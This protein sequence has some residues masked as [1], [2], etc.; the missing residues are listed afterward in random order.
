M[1]SQLQ[2]DQ[3]KTSQ[4]EHQYLN[5]YGI[6][7]DPFAADILLVTPE[8]E[9]LLRLLSH[10]V[11]YG[12]KLIV[13]TGEK[14][15][16]KTT[17]LEEFLRRQSGNERLCRISALKLD[18]PNQV[19]RE[20]SKAFELAADETPDKALILV[21]LSGFFTDLATDAE[22][23]MI[24]IDDAHLL[25][26]SVLEPLV[27]LAL[28]HSA[29]LQVILS[30]EPSLY[31]GLTALPLIQNNTQLIYRHSLEAFTFKDCKQYL[32][33][34]FNQ[35][36]QQ[37]SLPFSDAEF[38][39]IYQQSQGL[40]GQINRCT[41]QILE[42]GVER[43]LRGETRSHWKRASGVI[44]ALSVMV[45]STALFWPK[46]RASE[47]VVTPSVDISQPITVRRVERQSAAKASVGG[48]N[49]DLAEMAGGVVSAPITNR[50]EFE[51]SQELID[52]HTPFSLTE[53]RA[54]IDQGSLIKNK[55]E[56][57]PSNLLDD[58]EH[59]KT[60]T[61]VEENSILDSTPS[62]LVSG[63][64]DPSFSPD[65]E[66]IL[67]I[68]PNN[69]TVQLLGLREEQGILAMLKGLPSDEKYRYFRTEYQDG[70][71]YVLVYGDFS[72]RQQAVNAA[73]ALPKKL[74][75]KSA[76]IRRVSGI[77]K[78]LVKRNQD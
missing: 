10:L 54:K 41:Q 47:E 49:S 19:L 4:T 64:G 53:Q 27:E 25:K 69:Y 77:Q 17:I 20:I 42:D 63:E 48:L 3:I 70:P 34:L 18:T 68:D 38:L 52:S 73:A 50:L 40:P 11:N 31:E 29:S 23:C 5:Y 66:A 21:K 37:S 9:K 60:L 32:H 55:K 22:R 43:L 39:E 45:V 36:G 58:S 6:K 28:K 30:G 72:D 46:N 51:S 78:G 59:T 33:D 56:M 2:M 35:S 12:K 44:L 24:V 75:P 7:A 76:W 14:G 57:T 61:Q 65:E 71:W 8:L 74:R 13:L 62:T 15:A 26:R 16:G 67:A 1:S